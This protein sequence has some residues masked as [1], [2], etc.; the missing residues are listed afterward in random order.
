DR[1]VRIRFVQRA[2]GDSTQSGKPGRS[3]KSARDS[4]HAFRNRTLDHPNRR[5]SSTDSHERYPGSSVTVLS[6]TNVAENVTSV[7]P[8][9][10]GIQSVNLSQKKVG[11][12]D[13]RFRGDDDTR[14]H[15]HQD[16]CI[17]LII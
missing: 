11:N 10:A 14:H 1:H 5:R 2:S 12:L 7:I 13:P 6:N 4:A 3:K 16:V 8:A 15:F 9:K 17:S